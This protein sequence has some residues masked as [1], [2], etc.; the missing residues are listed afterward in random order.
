MIILCGA[1]SF[2][3]Q[4]TIKITHRSHLLFSFSDFNIVFYTVGPMLTKL[5][6]GWV[7]INHELDVLRQHEKKKDCLEHID[8]VINV[9]IVSTV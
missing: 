6:P 3:S 5:I 2:L 9:I 1:A 4:L 7:E 8:N